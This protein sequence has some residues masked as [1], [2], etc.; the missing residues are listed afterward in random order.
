[1]DKLRGR[2]L[3]ASVLAFAVAGSAQAQVVISQAYGGGGNSNAVYKSDFIELHN[4][5]STAVN[6]SGWSVQYASSAGSSWQVSK[7]NGTIAPGGYYLIKQADGNGS[8]GPLPTPDLIPSGT[9]GDVLIS[10][11]GT[12]F[13]LALVNNSTALSGACPSSASIVDLLGVGPDASCSETAPTALISNATAAIRNGAGCTDSN[14]NS[15]DFAVATPNAR[16]SATAANVC[17]G[18]PTQPTLSVADVSN[19]EGD[20]GVTAFVFTL[21]LNQPAG[22]GGVAWTASTVDGTATAGSD[23]TAL[24]NF[25]GTIP[26]GQSSATVTV[27]VNGDTVTEPNE[28]FKLRVQAV[29]GALPSTPIEATGTIVN[30]DYPVF[31]IHDIQGN[32]ARSPLEGQTVTT[33]GVVTARKSNGFFIQTTDAEADADPMTSEGVYVFTSSA[34]TAAAAIGNR[35]RVSGTIVEFIPPQDPGQLPLTELSFATYRQV[36]TAPL[37]VP[38]VLPVVQPTAPLDAL[39]PYEGMRVAIQSFKVTAP[40]TGNP[41]N[42]TNA[43]GSTRNFFFGVIGDVPRPFREAGIQPGDNPPA[44]SIPPIPRWDGNPELMQVDSAAAGAPKLEV[45]AGTTITGLVGPLDYGF[46]RYTLLIEPG[47]AVNVTAGPAPHPGVETVDP[48]AVSVAGYNLQRFFN[49]VRDSLNVK[50][51]PVLTADAYARRKQKASLGIRDYLKT[52]D[53]LGTVEVENL[54][55]LQDLA[56]KINADAVAAGQPDPNYVAYLVEGNDPGGI[57]VGYLI[58]TAEVLPGKPRVEVLAV[59]QIGKDTTWVQPDGNSA[60]LNDRPPLALDAVVHYA[61]GRDFPVNVVVVHQRSLGSAEDATDDG[62]RVRLK[63][64]RQAEFLATYLN[65][66]QTQNPATRLIVLGDFNAFEFNDGLTDVMGTVI[67]E[68][69]PDDATAVP[70]DGA[71]LV[72]PN[73]INLASLIHPMERYSYTFDGHAQSLDHTLV[74]E[75]MVVNTRSIRLTHP[76]LNADYPETNRN[77]ANSPSRLSDHDPMVT[78]LVP[79]EIADLGVT[80][81]ANAAS[82]EVGQ[83]LGYTATATNHGPGRADAVGVGFA[84][85]AELPSLSATQPAGWTCDAPQIAAGKT[86]LA[87]RTASLANG[88][89][90]SF[91]LSANASA[92][93]AGKTVKLAVAGSTEALDKVSANDT[94]EASVAVTAASNTTP[95][96]NGQPLIIDGAAG[97]SKMFRLEVPQ[98]LRAFRV[99]TQG[100]S[101]DVSLYLKRG[102]LANAGNYDQRSIRTGN[103]ETVTAV[104]PAAGTWYITVSGGAAA[105]A[106]VAV[107]TTFVP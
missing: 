103:S 52:P 84:L 14:N 58:K 38:V 12:T 23:Y 33:E 19:P 82:V 86:S 93:L 83:S 75:E 4:N 89:S 100:G 46:R 2:L 61:D 66:R 72:E 88:A 57:D 16:N 41:V 77:D 76:R 90:A 99:A 105:F 56:A 45:S 20:S 13:K 44:G 24:T 95:I 98:G 64:Q 53:I 18:G 62:A 81:A 79:R 31:A 17:G 48:S 50:D 40:N 49:A 97:E 104:A 25:A 8:Q 91:A 32:G 107:L 36:G 71:D 30:D 10:M 54:V 9:P 60:K 85:D 106:K 1:M 92:D 73:L 37:P 27:S 80:A 65:D 34:P 101:G 26:A 28:T 70:G 59:T 94:A 67:G 3:A 47:A 78:Y 21:S 51:E 7:L 39:E 102:S 22:A 69:S 68:P 35:V 15:A 63:R 87:C 55:T 42:E 74:N 29:S 43:T 5:G 96:F 11:S 6:L